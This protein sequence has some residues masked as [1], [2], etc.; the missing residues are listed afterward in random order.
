MPRHPLHLVGAHGELGARRL[1][2]SQRIDRALE[3]AAADRDIGA[4]VVEEALEQPLVL[5]FARSFGGG[6]ALAFSIM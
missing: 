6:G 4:V 3:R 5:G 1:K 2:R